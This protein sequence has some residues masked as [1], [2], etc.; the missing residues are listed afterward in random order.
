MS[1]EKK[2]KAKKIK[3]IPYRRMDFLRRMQRS[4]ERLKARR[5]NVYMGLAAVLAVLLLA[6]ALGGLFYRQYTL[7]GEVELLEGYINDEE[8]AALL[9]RAEALALQAGKQTAVIKDMANVSKNILSYPLVTS[10]VFETLE[11]SCPDKVSITITGY[12]SETGE[13]KFDAVA[14]EVTDVSEVIE[15]WKTLDIFQRVYYTGYTQNTSED[16]YTV[17]VVCVLSEQAGR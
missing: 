7:R 12:S 2:V 5:R 16:G 8:N 6:A 14:P 17:K 3:A 10:D 4:P 15:V 9:E 13:L 1:K 11:E